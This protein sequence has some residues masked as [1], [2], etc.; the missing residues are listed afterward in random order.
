MARSIH[1]INLLLLLSIFTICKSD[2]PD[3]VYTVYVRT[4]SII[5]GG[6]DSSISLTLYDA[7]GYGIRIRDLE[8]WGGLMGAG[9][10]YFERGN[11]D[12]FSG[13][14]P[15]L[16]GPVCAMNLTS[17]GSGS[18]HGWYV[19][20]VEVSTTGVHQAC[21]QR[22]FTVEQWL[23]TDTAPY[24]LTAVRTFC[25]ESYGKRGGGDSRLVAVM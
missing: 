7:G 13:R 11:L 16:T 10:N 18:G 19:N 24:E 22:K 3:C 15:C 9:Y 8:A 17:D 14:G 20:Y 6:T 12:I 23:A 5:K 2:E 1:F 25:S 4:G 21:A